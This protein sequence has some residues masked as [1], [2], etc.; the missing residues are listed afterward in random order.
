MAHRRHNPPPTGQRFTRKV[1]APY[2]AG[3][4]RCL[5]PAVRSPVVPPRGTP[6]MR[7]KTVS[8]VVNVIGFVPGLATGTLAVGPFLT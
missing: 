1:V 2:A 8:H 7:G 3:G 5:R 6:T 4:G